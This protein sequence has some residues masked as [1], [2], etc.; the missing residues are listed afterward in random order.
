MDMVRPLMFGQLGKCFGLSNRL[1]IM[2]TIRDLRIITYV[3]LCG[4]SPFRSEDIKLLIKET[5][6]A[7]VEFHERYWKNV[8]PQGLSYVLAS[9]P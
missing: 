7:K 9:L 5:T 1:E 2:L 8:S 4:Y 3:L 6:E